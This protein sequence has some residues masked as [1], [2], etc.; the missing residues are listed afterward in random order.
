[1]LYQNSIHLTW[2]HNFLAL[3]TWDLFSPAT[4]WIIIILFSSHTTLVL[5]DSSTLIASSNNIHVHNVCTLNITSCYVVSLSCQGQLC[6]LTI[7]QGRGSFKLCQ[8][9]HVLS[10]KPEKDEKIKNKKLCKV[11][12]KTAL[13]IL[14]HHPPTHPSIYSYDTKSFP[15]NFPH[16]NET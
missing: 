14:C 12:Q 7:V 15:Q 6:H 10:K 11:R 1:M 16:W 9:E 5:S 13:K 2:Y 4:K 8:N 3:M